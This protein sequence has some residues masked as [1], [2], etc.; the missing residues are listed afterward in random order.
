M[1]FIHKLIQ[2]FKPKKKL[3]DQVQQAVQEKSFFQA[4][5]KSYYQGLNK[6]ANSFANTINKLAANY[7]TVNEQFQESL[8]EELVLLDIGYHAATKICDAIVQELKLQRVSDPQLIQEIIVDKLI[9]Y[10]I[11]DKL[12]ETDLTVEANKTNVYLFVGVN[13]VG[14][15]TSLAKLADQLTKQNKR[16][17]MV[18]GDTFRAGAV[19]QLA[20]W[21]QRIG[22]DIVLPN[23][24]EET[25]AVIFRGVQQGIQNEYDFVLCDTSGRLQNKTNLMNELKKIYQIV[26]KVSSAKPQETLLVLDGTTGQSGLAQAKVFNEFTELTGIILTKMDS[27][28]KGGIILAI[29]DLFNLPVK[30]I[31][32]GETTADLAAFDLEQ[33]VLGLTKNLSL[34]HEPNQT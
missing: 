13:G 19:A 23:P 32:F 2:K 14:K 28:S 4:N 3:V 30:L 29:K 22:C 12:F 9:V 6:S 27:S 33:Y 5:Q 16:V 26:Q 21:A 15:T 25:P 34:N 20:E 7:V 24:K 10:Y 31:G 17:L 18:A 1:S 8:F 11:Q